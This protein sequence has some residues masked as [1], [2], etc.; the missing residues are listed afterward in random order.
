MTV[1]ELQ[2]ETQTSVLTTSFSTFLP[3][4]SNHPGNVKNSNLKFGHKY[5]LVTH[6]HI[7][8]FIT[9]VKSIV[10]KPQPFLI[11]NPFTWYLYFPGINIVFKV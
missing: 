4:Y 7:F 10:K 5:C 1:V 11:V 2:T 3:L 9:S 8:R 6:F